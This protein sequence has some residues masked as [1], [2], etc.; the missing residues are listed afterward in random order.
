MQLWGETQS[1]YHLVGS[2]AKA[3]TFLDVC[4]PDFVLCD[5]Y[6]PDSRGIKTLCAMKKAYN[7]G[8]LVVMSGYLT[9]MEGLDAIRLGAHEYLLR[10]DTRRI[11]LVAS[12]AWLR[13]DYQQRQREGEQDDLEQA[14][15]DATTST[16]NDIQY[17]KVAYS[18]A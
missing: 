18:H 5:L 9:N 1:Q 11:V 14:R 3:L 16:C 13:W 7:D 4:H 10:G 2:L 8:P 12:R 15:R 6:L 17:A